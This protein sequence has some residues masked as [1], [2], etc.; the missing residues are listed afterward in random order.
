[1]S[2]ARYEHPL[3]AVICFSSILQEEVFGKFENE[4]QKEYVDHTK[5]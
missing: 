5:D 2:A 4:R 3:N 1:M